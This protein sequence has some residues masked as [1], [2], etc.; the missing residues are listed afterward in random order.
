MA[1]QQSSAVPMRLNETPLE[2]VSIP[3]LAFHLAQRVLLHPTTIKLVGAFLL[4]SLL[5]Y[6]RFSKKKSIR[7]K[8]VVVTGAGN[9]LGRAQAME[10]A[11][12]GCKVIVWDIDAE[13]I[14]K[15]AELVK[16]KYPT[17]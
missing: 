17:A 13:G 15:T 1:A 3:Q 10:L 4:I 8:T 7:G 11:K 14:K 6:K 12:Q 2:H 5:L 16:A 9:G